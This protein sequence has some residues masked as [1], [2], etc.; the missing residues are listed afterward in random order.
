MLVFGFSQRTLT[1]NTCDEEQSTATGELCQTQ[2]V[3]CHSPARKRSVC[4]R[5][6]DETPG[7]LL[8]CSGE[9]GYSVSTRIMGK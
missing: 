2:C 7:R 9:E 6:M 5:E 3:V 1:L 4:G 8:Q